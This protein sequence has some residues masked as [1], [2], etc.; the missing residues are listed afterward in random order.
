MKVQINSD[1]T[2]KDS[3]EYL[4]ETQIFEKNLMDSLRHFQNYISKIIVRFSDV[5]G[6]KESFNDKRCLIEVRLIGV[7]PIITTHQANN[8]HMALNGATDKAKRSLSH[9]FGKMKKR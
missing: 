6:S 7:Q 9:L 2:I 5:N 8:L 1:Q 4:T 3:Y